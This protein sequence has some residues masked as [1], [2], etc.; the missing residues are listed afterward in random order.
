MVAA[1]ALDRLGL[2]ERATERLSPSTLLPQVGQGGLA[3]ECR[4]EDASTSAALDEID[5]A[6]AH[7][8]IR[9]ERAFLE[10][11]GGGCSLPCGALARLRPDGSLYLEALLATLDG[12]IVLRVSGEGSDPDALGADVARS[13]LDDH[14]GRVVLGAEVAR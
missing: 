6:G 8:E 10:Q 4:T 9:A 5:D 12:R 1:A 11:L 14:G 13:L 7:L 3:V 2:A